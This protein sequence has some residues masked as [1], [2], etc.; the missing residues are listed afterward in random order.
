VGAGGGSAGAAGVGKAP[1]VAL[2]R[3]RLVS[4]LPEVGGGA[5]PR[6]LHVDDALAAVED[7]A[8]E[9]T[10]GG[11]APGVAL[12]RLRLF[13]DLPEVADDEPPRLLL[14]DEAL[15]AVEVGAG[16]ASRT[17]WRGSIPVAAGGA[18][19]LDFSEAS[20]LRPLPCLPT[21]AGALGSA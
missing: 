10:G 12:S 3:L 5:P 17:C 9:A 14:A 2:S 15:T 16:A 7:G 21:P 13:A 18:S 1:G 4:E 8:A 19:A 11:K 20:V 6:L